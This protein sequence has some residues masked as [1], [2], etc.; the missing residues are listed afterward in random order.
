M[1]PVGFKIDARQR[2]Q[3]ADGLVI[4]AR[5]AKLINHKRLTLN[6]NDTTLAPPM[7]TTSS[8]T[9]AQNINNNQTISYRESETTTPTTINNT[10]LADVEPLKSGDQLE[11]FAISI[12]SGN[13][14]EQI[15]K[16]FVLQGRDQSIFLSNRP[17]TRRPFINFTSLIKPTKSSGAVQKKYVIID[18][19]KL[20]GNGTEV[21]GRSAGDWSRRKSSELRIQVDDKPTINERQRSKKKTLVKVKVVNGKDQILVYTSTT[22]PSPMTTITEEKETTTMM[23]MPAETSNTVNA[24]LRNDNVQFEKELETTT[25]SPTTMTTTPI[26]YTTTSRS[27][28]GRKKFKTTTMSTT[29]ALTTMMTFTTTKAATPPPTTTTKRSRKPFTTVIP[30]DLPTTSVTTTTYPSV[31]TLDIFPASSMLPE[32]YFGS[33]FNPFAPTSSTEMPY[34]SSSSMSYLDYSGEFNDFGGGATSSTIMPPIDVE[35]LDKNESGDVISSTPLPNIEDEV[36]PIG[37]NGTLMPT[38]DRDMS[39]TGVPMAQNEETG[40]RGKLSSLQIVL[41]GF[42]IAI[43]SIIFVLVGAL[44]YIS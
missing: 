13:E 3:N 11:G 9:I 16:S 26:S 42:L 28:Y 1:S 35:F 21:S 33:Q 5:S 40:R 38:S 19:R 44:A 23:T 32:Q 43:G 20:K 30:V 41:I 37:R 2:E 15:D 25:T 18:K 10:T 6:V 8:T 12:R 7:T 27:T 24:T 39:T 17:S 34:Y 4:N 14:S 31:E 22:T 29:E 36:K